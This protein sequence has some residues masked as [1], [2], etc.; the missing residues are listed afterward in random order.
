MTS[1]YQLQQESI[2]LTIGLSTTENNGNY[3]VKIEIVYTS[4]DTMVKI[5]FIVE[6]FYT[7][8]DT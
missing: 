2:A 3:P 4:F 6:D 7:L 5:I 8:N 1:T